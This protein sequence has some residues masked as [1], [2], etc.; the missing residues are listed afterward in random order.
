MEEILNLKTINNFIDIGNN[1]LKEFNAPLPNIIEI[2][3]TNA[4]SYWGE[5]YRYRDEYN[6][7]YYCM[8]ISRAFN[9][10]KNKEEA[11]KC[12]QNTV[13]H[14]M[15]HTLDGCWDHKYKFNLW[16][17]KILNKFPCIDILEDKMKFNYAFK[18]I[19]QPKYKIKCVD[20]GIEF[21]LYRK[22]KN[23]INYY[24]CSKCGSNN[25]KYIEN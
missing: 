7:K 14:E 10:I 6:N 5:I 20:C 24:C 22:L 23:D 18:S 25:I 19:K 21:H 15:I 4:I 13:I 17:N 2:K 3:I 11:L 1:I 8:Y 9:Y 16:R 12:L